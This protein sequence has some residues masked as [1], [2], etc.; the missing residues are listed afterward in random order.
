VLVEPW[1]MPTRVLALGGGGGSGNFG[2]NGIQP[3]RA[4]CEV[5][6][7]GNVTGQARH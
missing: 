5:Y 4:S 2:F 1:V 6:E 7:E 3:E